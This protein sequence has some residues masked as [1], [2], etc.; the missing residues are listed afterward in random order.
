MRA[1]SA[2]CGRCA[3]CV[4]REIVGAGVG[5]RTLA[6]AAEYA[7]RGEV[8]LE[9]RKQWQSGALPAY[10]WTSGR[11]RPELQSQ[12]GRALSVW[13]EA[14]WA[15]LVEAG[16]AAGRFSDELVAACADLINGRWRPT[17]KP[18]WITCIL[19]RRTTIMPDFAQRLAAALRVSFRPAVSKVRDTPRQR[20][21]A[22]GWQQA[23]NLDGA[24]A[25]DEEQVL[26]GPVLLVDDIVDSRW[27]LTIV[28]AL[29][30]RAGA[31]EVFSL[32]LCQAKSA[33]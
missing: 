25:V 9:P 31:G 7:R 16:K 2:P 20:D 19:S 23:H 11:I 24:F 4:E 14:G 13:G 26:P 15:P 12:V 1:S 21:M 6:A 18:A 32:A 29:L 3:V 27:S 8:R 5:R 22:N 28:A 33:L 30:R 17:P 10:G